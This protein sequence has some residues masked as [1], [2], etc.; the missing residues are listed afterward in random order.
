MLVAMG[1]PLYLGRKNIPGGPVIHSMRQ[2]VALAVLFLLA[3]I[4]PASAQ[5]VNIVPAPE[6][7]NAFLEQ[8]E[9]VVTK[10]RDRYLALAMK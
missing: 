4:G 1:K 5:E 3:V 6:D 2:L 7:I 10:L 9:P 8:L